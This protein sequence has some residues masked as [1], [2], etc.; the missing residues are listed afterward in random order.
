[1]SSVAI[2]CRANLDPMYSRAVIGSALA[3]GIF[4]VLCSYAWVF[5]T[6]F[7]NFVTQATGADPWRNLGKVFWGTGGAV[8]ENGVVSYFHAVFAYRRWIDQRR[9]GNA[10]PLWIIPPMTAFW[11]RP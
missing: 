2:G 7:N 5:G 4:Y 10:E 11:R 6:G 1:M 8:D 3:I 9:P